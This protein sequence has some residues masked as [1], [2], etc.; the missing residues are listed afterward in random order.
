[1]LLDHR[2]IRLAGRPAYAVFDVMVAPVALVGVCATTH[3]QS[4]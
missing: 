2:P 1:M 3:A 4:I